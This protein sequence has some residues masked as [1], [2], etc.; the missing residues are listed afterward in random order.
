MDLRSIVG[1]NV[2]KL[3]VAKKLSQEAVAHDAEISRGYF[4]QIES[5]KTFY[6]SIKVLGR[7][8][9]ALEVEPAEFFKLPVK[10]GRGR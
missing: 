4:N 6:V 1:T 2:R 5:G 8:A 7:L 9:D 10:T 3:R